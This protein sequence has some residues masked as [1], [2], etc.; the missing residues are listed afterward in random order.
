MYFDKFKKHC[1]WAH[2]SFEWRTRW[3]VRVDHLWL[4]FLHFGT[5]RKTIISETTQK[6]SKNIDW[7]VVNPLLT[8]MDLRTSWLLQTG[9]EIDETYLEADSQPRIKTG[10]SVGWR[11]Q[12]FHPKWVEITKYPSGQIS[13]RPRLGPQFRELFGRDPMG[14]PLFCRKKSEKMGEISYIPC[15]HISIQP[16]KIH[17][18]CFV[19]RFFFSGGQTPNDRPIEWSRTPQIQRSK[20]PPKS[21]RRNA[22]A[23]GPFSARCEMP[24]DVV[25]TWSD[26]QG[27]CVFF[28]LGG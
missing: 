16:K 27:G 24:P 4:F 8:M 11:T 5:W 25:E 9:F 15:G 1:S 12:S 18:A 19:F 26:G 13:S 21:W 10:F 22:K 2:H 17:R 6:I 23:E 14:P 7:L 3:S 28:L 20:A